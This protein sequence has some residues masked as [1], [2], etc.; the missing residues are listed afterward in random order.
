LPIVVLC[1]PLLYREAFV[2][3]SPAFSC[4]FP[5]IA[6]FSCALLGTFCYIVAVLIMINTW[7]A[8]A[9]WGANP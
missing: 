1:C 7:A 2:L 5:S 6:S 8:L 9:Q 4:Y 3:P